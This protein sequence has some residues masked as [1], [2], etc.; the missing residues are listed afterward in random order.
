[1][2]KQLE[3]SYYN[4][5]VLY[6]GKDIGDVDGVAWHVEE[7]RIKGDFNGKSTDYGARAYTT[8]NEYGIRR[9]PNAMIYSGVYNSKTKTNNTNQFSIAESIT[10]AVD[11]ASGSIQ[12]LHAEDG[13]LN[14]FQQH[15]V[16]RALIDK[17]A[18]YTA[19]GLGLT[20]TGVQVIGQVV[21]YVGKYGISD[22][23]ESFA[24][25]GSRKYFVDRQRGAVMRLSQNGLEPI[26][27]Y[28]M[29]DF[30]RD[31]LKK[32]RARTSS[33]D[34]EKGKVFGMYDE[35]HGEYIISLQRSNITG[36]KK[37]GSNSPSTSA[38]NG[39]LTLGFS[40]TSN[41]WV[42]FYSYKPTFGFSMMNEFY[43][44]N[45]DKLYVH[46]AENGN[47]NNFYESTYN[48][49]SYVTL[50]MSDAA[51]STKTF[52]TINY[53]GSTGWRMDKAQA[54][55]VSKPGYN[56]SV[57]K[58]EAYKIPENGVTIVGADGL[59]IDV[60]F[61]RKESKYYAEL[62]QK[63]PYNPSDYNAT[64][65]SN[66]LNTTLGIKGYHLEIDMLYHE[67]TGNGK[68]VELFAVSNE[69]KI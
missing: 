36:G 21:P 5:F 29:N 69:I 23:P 53:E 43:T 62:K 17:D 64:F 12:H 2:A 13:N 20:T 42:S 31:N 26:S 65:N 47:Y 66:T 30:F 44:F 41:G 33:G 63:V 19:E 9:R 24:Y 25:F 18:V 11:I 7:S 50:I 61:K 60:G 45:A 55:N 27:K 4:S 54:E 3:I 57:Q 38:N 68:L 16:S 15:R 51:S 35:R 49:P 6:G 34:S 22:N 40:E 1:M 58:E 46:Y 56:N 59:P 39:F 10:R 67:P 37:T 8:D 48:D 28:G 14:I 52:M 32:L